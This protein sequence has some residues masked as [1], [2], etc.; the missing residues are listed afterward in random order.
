[1]LKSENHL[2]MG[3]N[4]WRNHVPAGLECDHR[5]GMSQPGAPERP[6]RCCSAAIWPDTALP[7]WRMSLRSCRALSWRSRRMAP[8]SPGV[9]CTAR[10]K[11]RRSANVCH[12]ASELQPGLKSDGTVVAW[13]Q[14]YGIAVGRS[15]QCC[16]H[17]RRR[18]RPGARRWHRRGRGDNR[19]A[20]P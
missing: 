18:E 11:S 13:G 1:V 6:H 17:C 10:R 12:P 19:A 16:R 14:L 8:S 15:D 9:I 5:R 7:A 2:W 20:S 4:Q 3:F